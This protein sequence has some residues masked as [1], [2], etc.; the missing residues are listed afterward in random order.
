MDKKLESILEEFRKEYKEAYKG[1]LS[2]RKRIKDKIIC[3]KP[4]N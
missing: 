1:I 4:T 3:K 2:D